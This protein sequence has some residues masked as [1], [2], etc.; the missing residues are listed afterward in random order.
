L[1]IAKVIRYEVKP[2]YTAGLYSPNRAE[3][4]SII[5]ALPFHQSNPQASKKISQI[6][7]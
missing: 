2:N 1:D 6:I 4:A 3:V 7:N 5:N